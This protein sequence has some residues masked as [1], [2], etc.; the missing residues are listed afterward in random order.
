M[1]QTFELEPVNGTRRNEPSVPRV[2]PDTESVLIATYQAELDDARARISAFETYEPSEVLGTI[3][4]IAGR[5]AEMRANLYRLNTQRCAALRTREV[6]P[7]RED[8]ELQFR[9]WSRKI[10]LMEW[11]FKVS[12]GGV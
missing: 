8:L 9:V 3:S 6:D 10:A 12:G 4:G 2:K 1:G 11:E 7:L 5:V